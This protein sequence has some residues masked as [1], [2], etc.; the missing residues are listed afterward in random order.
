[1][2][3][4]RL[5]IPK[6]A[7]SVLRTSLQPSAPQPSS[8]FA[9]AAARQRQRQQQRSIHATPARCLHSVP[10]LN[11]DGK[12]AKE[13]VPGVYTSEGFDVAYTKYQTWC[14]QRLNTLIAGTSAA[15]SFP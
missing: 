1:M 12:L 9:A 13:G 10:P 2:F 6:G 7:G 15:P 5:R 4:P 14:L 11:D 3:K 8:P